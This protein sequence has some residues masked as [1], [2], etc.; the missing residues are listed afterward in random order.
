MKENIG[1]T[2][3]TRFLDPEILSK[4]SN[5]ELLARTVVEGFVSGLHKS[6]YRGFSVEFMEYRPYIPGDDMARI[7]WKLYARSDRLYVKEYEDETNTSCN[8]LLDLSN[9]MGYTSSKIN[10]YDYGSF[11]AASL[12]YFIIRQ[13]DSVGLSLFDE[14][15]IQ[16]ISPKSTTGH[17]YSILT[18]LENSK[19]GKHT[20]F[21]KP[22]HELA[23]AIKRKRFIIVISD[24]LQEPE[25]L[26]D[27]LKHF[28]FDGHEVI[29]FHIL[30][31][32]ELNFQ[33]NDIIELEDMET[34]EKVLV[35]PESAKEIYQKN[36][37]NF[38]KTVKKECGILGIDYYTLSTDKPL[39]FALFQYLSSRSQKLK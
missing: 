34:G 1:N 35:S 13:R 38:R 6:P 23:D 5:L 28:R 37:E 22:F 27:G 24:L 19:L 15:I 31:P 29:V 39:D 32:Y 20:A 8:I 21:G 3:G 7:D 18:T 12:A 4:I 26:I 2:V 36:L 25:G 14:K 33:F 17:L 30:D 16:R 10:K 11:L 9:S